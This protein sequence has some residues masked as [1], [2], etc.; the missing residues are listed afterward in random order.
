MSST[1]MHTATTRQ[2]PIGRPAGA[3]ALVRLLTGWFNLQAKQR[4]RRQ[5][6]ELD[7]RLLRDIGIDRATAL[8]EAQRSVWQ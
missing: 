7:P 4:S 6:A 3:N 8:D 1:L 5:L 2:A